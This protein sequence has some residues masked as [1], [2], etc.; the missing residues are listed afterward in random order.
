METEKRIITKIQ[1]DEIIKKT[2]ESNPSSECEFNNLLGF[3]AINLLLDSLNMEL[4]EPNKL[5]GGKRKP[6]RKTKAKRNKKLRK[7]RKIRKY[8][9]GADPRIVIFFMSMFLIFVQGIQNMT[10]V[11]VTNRLKQTMSSIDLFKNYYG[12]CA[13]NTL[14]F[15]KT[16]DLRT[17]EELSIELME[18]KKGMTKYEMSPYLNSELNFDTRWYMFTGKEGLNEE[19]SIQRFID[20]VRNKLISMRSD[21][22]FGPEQEILTA[23]NYP[24]KR[25]SYHAVTVWLTNKNEIVIIDPQRYHVEN[26]IELYTSEAYMDRYMDNDKQLIMS[27]IQ[28]Y[29]RERIDVMSDFRD[30]Q[31]LLSLHIEIDDVKGK[32]RLN[33]AN[34]ELQNVIGRIRATEEKLEDKKRIEF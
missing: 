23:L 3:N 31:V 18:T 11:D 25:G 30:S 6:K 8:K 12:T 16:I 29:I 34:R 24:T 13:V 4:N 26:R 27:P 22:G 5:T 7:T 17:F 2:L 19:E 32:N 20:N 33:P 10:H 21:Y 14:L 15:L 9:G 1:I 28:T